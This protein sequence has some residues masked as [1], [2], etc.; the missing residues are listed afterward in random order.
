MILLVCFSLKPTETIIDILPVT[1][2][3]SPALPSDM[4]VGEMKLKIKWENWHLHPHLVE[5][6]SKF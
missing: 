5:K 1:L 3:N 6:H 2:A 4:Y